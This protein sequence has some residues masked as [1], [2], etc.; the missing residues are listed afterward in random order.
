MPETMRVGWIGTGVMGGPMAG[1]LLA[2]GY[3]L[4]VFNRTR[5]KAEKLLRL[6]AKWALSPA[7]VAQASDV[8]FT[9]VCL[10]LFETVL[11]AE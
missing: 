6:G 2:A 1:H 9:I 7:A 5:A 8:V 3:P 11:N 10:L 4:T